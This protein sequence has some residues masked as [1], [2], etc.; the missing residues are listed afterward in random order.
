[1]HS[2]LFQD[3]ECYSKYTTG[4]CVILLLN[5]LEINR[6]HTST[7]ERIY[8]NILTIFKKMWIQDVIHIQSVAIIIY[9]YPLA[10]W[11]D[12]TKSPDASFEAFTVVMDLWRVGILQHYTASQPRRHQFEKSAEFWPR[13]YMFN[14]FR[15]SA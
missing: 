1:M 4:E 11:L 13:M 8:S 14:G 2:G 6:R 12:C 3:G 9:T 10:N 7:M 15:N 5:T